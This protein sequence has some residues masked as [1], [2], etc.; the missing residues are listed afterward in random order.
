ME[1]K[2]NQLIYRLGHDCTMYKLDNEI[3]E[4]CNKFDCGAEDLND[5][6][7]NNAIAYDDE[8]MGKTY[9]WLDNKDNS[10]IIAMIT[11]AN[12]GL[13]TTH[14]QNN[15]K[16]KL[17][18]NISFPKRSRTYPAVLIGR[19]GVNKKYQSASYKIG[20]QVM[21]FI[22]RWFKGPDNK[23]GCRFVLVDA[24]NDNHAIQYYE[25]NGFLPLFP[26]IEDEKSFYDI[27]EN[28]QLRTRMYYFDLL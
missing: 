12:A 20:A 4:N 13:H 15:P 14:L 23:T 3:L 24:V 6:F 27:D 26:R 5:F 22:K 9:C 16:R 10:Q 28:E 21:D 25:R 17:N 8:L 2:T 1:E 7:A 19:L 11:L 18:K